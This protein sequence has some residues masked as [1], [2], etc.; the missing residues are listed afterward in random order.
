[1]S[2]FREN[3]DAVT[4]AGVRLVIDRTIEQY[5]DRVSF[6]GDAGVGRKAWEH[7]IFRLVI[8]GYVLG[9]VEKG[10]ETVR[11]RFPRKKGNANCEELAGRFLLISSQI[12]E[13]DV[14]STPSADVREALVQLAVNGCEELAEHVVDDGANWRAVE[15]AMG[16]AVHR[17]REIALSEDMYVDSKKRGLIE[18]VWS[19]ALSENLRRLQ[20]L[21]R[22]LE[23][24]GIA[25]PEG[26]LLREARDG[27]RRLGRELLAH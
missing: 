8:D 27:L 18:K 4:R 26:S 3:V 14:F 13:N 25:L 7:Q 17:G 1:V 9:R 23:K 21:Q 2:S 19:E 24:Q 5:G 11:L 22:S 15:E 20:D 6:A 12:A 16:R 10:T